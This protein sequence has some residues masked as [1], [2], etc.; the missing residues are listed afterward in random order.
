MGSVVSRTNRYSNLNKFAEQNINVKSGTESK[1]FQTRPNASTSV[2]IDER[3]ESSASSNPD[4]SPPKVVPSYSW[5][6]S[7]PVDLETA[8]QELSE[9]A[10][11]SVQSKSEK[12]HCVGLYDN[13]RLQTPCEN[14]VAELSPSN[15]KK[16][17]PRNQPGSPSC[18]ARKVNKQATHVSPSLTPELSCGADTLPLRRSS[19]PFGFGAERP[20]TF[21]GSSH[22]D[23]VKSKQGLCREKN[24]LKTERGTKMC[25]AKSV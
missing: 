21:S 7:S 24:L 19:V 20:A 3:H 9:R 23:S 13:E 12:K 10:K 16:K 1:E 15:M 6:I 14:T 18:A 5:L 8:A 11:H 2:N 17:I 25:Q 22:Q 4:F